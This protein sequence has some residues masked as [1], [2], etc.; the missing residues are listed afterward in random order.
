[1]PV[2]TTDRA[3]NP[4]AFALRNHRRNRRA[5]NDLWNPES[6]YVELGTPCSVRLEDERAGNRPRSPRKI[7]DQRSSARD[8][9]KPMSQTD[10]SGP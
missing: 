7:R 10:P 2:F 9:R 1:M 8:G 4:P 3:A 6:R 5:S